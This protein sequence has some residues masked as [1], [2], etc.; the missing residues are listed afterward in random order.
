MIRGLKIVLPLLCLLIWMETAPAETPGQVGEY[1]FILP[2]GFELRYYEDSSLKYNRVLMIN[3]PF[4]QQD[5]SQAVVYCLREK[6]TEYRGYTLSGKERIYL[7]LP[8]RRNVQVY[9][10]A[11][12]EVQQNGIFSR[13]SL[14]EE[15]SSNSREIRDRENFFVVIE[16]NAQDEFFHTLFF[17]CDFRKGEGFFDFEEYKSKV[18]GAGIQLLDSIRKQF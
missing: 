12:E 10:S 14:L 6:K 9:V 13:F 7:Q 2:E 1:G 3:Q 5:L 17:I 4:N 16:M 11:T 8:T 18:T 15:K